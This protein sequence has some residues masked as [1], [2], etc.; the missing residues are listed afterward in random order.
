MSKESMQHLNTNTLIGFTNNRGTA[1]HYRAEDQG[2]ESNHYEEAIPV[3]DVKRRL[4]NWT[5]E[6]RPIAAQVPSTPELM[7]HLDDDGLP[8][9]WALIDGRQAITRSDTESVMGIFTA[10]YERHQYDQWLLT[11]VANILDDTLSISS[12]GL[13]RGGAIAWVE[14]S[15]PEAIMTPEGVEFRPNLLAITSFDGS[16][17]TTFKRTITATV[18]DNTRDLALSEAGQQ[19]KVKHSRNSKLRLVEARDA[20]AVVHQTADAF[21][22]EVEQLCRIEVDR[23]AWASFL[24]AHIAT[25]TANGHP[26]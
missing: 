14:V 21:A 20:L 7:S 6:S 16:I 4:F 15:V 2:V 3:D 11:S 13:L 8:V 19:L 22:L 9:R 23:A 10:G 5:A 25:V 17:A 18:C 24:D 26:L 1:W 12:A